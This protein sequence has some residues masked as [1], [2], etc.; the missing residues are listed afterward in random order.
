MLFRTHIWGILIAEDAEMAK[1]RSCIS[2][3]EFD[4]AVARVG[5]KPY[6]LIAARVNARAMESMIRSTS[7][8]HTEKTPQSATKLKA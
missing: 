3:R 8:P 6:S 7:S 4:Q 2:T 1:Q 5:E